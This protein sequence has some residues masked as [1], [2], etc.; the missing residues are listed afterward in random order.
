MNDD[1][2]GVVAAFFAHKSPAQSSFALLKWIF[3]MLY[4][5]YL[6]AKQ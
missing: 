2:G 4:R 1:D 3:D 6:H 5:M